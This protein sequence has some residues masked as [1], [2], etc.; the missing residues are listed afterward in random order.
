MHRVFPNGK[1]II[2]I[3][4]QKDAVESYYKDDIKLGFLGDYKSWLEYRANSYQ[5]NYFKY[6]N[7]I[8]IYF[9]IFGKKNVNV[10]LFEKLFHKDYLKNN[11]ENFGLDTSGIENVNFNKKYNKTYLPLTLKITPLINR[12]FGS[13]LT[14]GVAHG[15]DP[16][17]RVYNLWRNY[18]SKYFNKL[19]LFVKMK[20]FN[21]EFSGYDNFLND[22]FHTDNEKL[23]ELI[24]IDLKKYGYF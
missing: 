23:S 12:I 20:K 2:I 9:E 24:D 13:K 7:M 22:Q 14:H 17:L 4:N 19:S 21:L 15:N 16:R 18:L 6:Y 5:L 11:L 10:I 1:V 8:K 3:R